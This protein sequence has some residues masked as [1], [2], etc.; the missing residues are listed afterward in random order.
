[1]FYDFSQDSEKPADVDSNIDQLVRTLSLMPAN[2]RFFL[3]GVGAQAEFF[4]K[5]LESDL[6]TLAAIAT[7]PDTHV[8]SR[9]AKR[10][11]KKLEERKETTF[12]RGRYTAAV[13]KKHGYTH[14]LVTGCPS[15]MVSTDIH[16]GVTLE[17]RY[18]S[19]ASRVGDTT[20]KLAINIINKIGVNDM[21]MKLLDRYPNSI[22]FAQ[23]AADLR[24]LQR[25][26]FPFDRV[27]FYAT[28]VEAW[29]DEMKGMDACIGSRIHGNMIA[30][31]V[32]VP[33]FV[34]APDHRVLELVDAMRVPH[35]DIFDRRLLDDNI[36]SRRS[37]NPMTKK[38][39]NGDAGQMGMG[40]RERMTRKDDDEEERERGFDVA[41]LF[42]DA[43]FNGKRF[44]ENRCRI[45]QT[46]HRVFGAVGMDITAHVKQIAD[47]C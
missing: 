2:A 35:T 6:G 7:G 33:V 11:F 25:R 34:I 3:L 9:A 24:M 18:N 13:A 28:D 26:N 27:R 31:S 30:L 8:V 36:G 47:I 38:S 23:H 19:I 17:D 43:K 41:A 15:L 32:G 10:L 22:V 1:M 44:D 5:N 40:R 4:P 46:Y 14:G 37:G 20:L 21:Y 42:R 45:A 39:A 16:L 12:F 29:R